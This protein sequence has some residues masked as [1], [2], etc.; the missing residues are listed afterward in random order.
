MFGI[1]K[2]DLSQ[3]FN[4]YFHNPFLVYEDWKE[5]YWYAEYIPGAVELNGVF[6]RERND[7]EKWI[8]RPV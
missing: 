4:P 7:L 5:W 6:N 1:S 8:G 2:K 3:V